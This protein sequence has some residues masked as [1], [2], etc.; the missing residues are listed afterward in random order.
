M[1]GVP[2]ASRIGGHVAIVLRTRCNS[3]NLQ[4]LLLNRHRLD[5]S[6]PLSSKLVHASN[7]T[8]AAALILCETSKVSLNSQSRPL[9]PRS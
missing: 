9:R 5:P 4:F 8:Q 1:S 7:P 6:N 2:V 3:T